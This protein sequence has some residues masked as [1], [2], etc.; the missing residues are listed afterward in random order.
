M[1]VPDHRLDC[2]Y[3]ADLIE[4]VVRIYGYDRI[5]VTELADRLP[6]QRSNRDLEL[7]EV[8]RDILIGCGL[9]EVITYSLTN[10]EREAALYPA[11]TADDVRKDA[12][13]SLSNPISQERSVMRRSLLVT[14]LETAAA[15]LRFRDRV[16][17]F[18]VGKV[19][20][21]ETGQELPEEPRH[22]S[23]VITGPRS[24]RHWLATEGPDLDFFDLKGVVEALLARL[25]VADAVFE[26]AE[27]PTFQQGRTA[28]VLLGG[29][30]QS[31]P[32]GFLG[33]LE[34]AVRGAFGLPDRRVAAAELNLDALLAHVP[35][36]WFVQPISP[37]PAALQDLAIIVDEKVPAGVVQKLIAESGGF[38]LKDVR[39]FDVYRG[40]P[41]PEGKK[42]LAYA[43]TFQAPDKTLRDAIVTKQ[44]QRIVQHLKKELGAEL[45]S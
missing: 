17:I 28:R 20:L 30:G 11:Q 21:L 1:T 44:V 13:V 7:E 18:E 12:Y 23:I 14:G 38:L 43:L 37:Y 42:S 40:E 36:A 34:P 2:Q 9:Q 35:V 15:N 32:I 39:L 4:E 29:S 25:H 24:E 19:F 26:P 45:R 22:L 6:P 31:V 5:P 33:E 8:V 10:L 27:H 16:E 3:P 41:V